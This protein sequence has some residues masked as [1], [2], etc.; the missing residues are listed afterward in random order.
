MKRERTEEFQL[1]PPT[2]T[3]KAFPLT[4]CLSPPHLQDS[5][6]VLVSAAVCSL[7]AG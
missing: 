1:L 3:P 4:L 7:E 2:Y 6:L 5:E